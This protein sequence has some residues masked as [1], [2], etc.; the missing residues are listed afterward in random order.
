MNVRRP[1]ANDFIVRVQ[2]FLVFGK[3]GNQTGTIHRGRC[4]GKIVIA[5][6]EFLVCFLFQLSSPQNL[7][8]PECKIVFRGKYGILNWT[9]GNLPAAQNQK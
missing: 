6:D 9:V 2:F 5:V 7:F 3:R 4:V 1:E 8:Y